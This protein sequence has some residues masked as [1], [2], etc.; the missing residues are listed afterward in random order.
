MVLETEAEMGVSRSCFTWPVRGSPHNDAGDLKCHGHRSMLWGQALP[1][2]PGRW[3]QV[4]LVVLGEGSQRGLSCL[5][6]FFLAWVP[7]GWSLLGRGSPR[8]T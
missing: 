6:V 3:H 7:V 5:G 8:S 4:E 2:T 1:S